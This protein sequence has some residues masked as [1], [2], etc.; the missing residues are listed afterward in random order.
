MRR[1][2]L[3][4][5]DPRLQQVSVRAEQGS[6]DLVRDLRETAAAAN[7]AG[8][9]AIQIGVLERLMLVRTE[10]NEFLTM[11]NPKLLARQGGTAI[12]GEGCLSVPGFIEP[13]R[14]YKQ[15]VVRFMTI[16]GT[17]VTTT[18]NGRQAQTVQHELEHLDGHIFLEKLSRA[19]REVIEKQ[20]Q[21]MVLAAGVHAFPL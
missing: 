7:G 10:D 20:L 12:M 18:M 11:Y 17:Y 6:G 8:I 5:P 9:S 4:W 19:R 21:D 2:I 15:V 16:L 3:I 1:E 13:V 14:R